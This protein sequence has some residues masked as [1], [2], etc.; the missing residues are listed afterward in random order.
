MV[1]YVDVR[2]TNLPEEC[3]DHVWTL[4]GIREQSHIFF[5]ASRK[6]MEEKKGKKI[7]NMCCLASVCHLIWLKRRAQPGQDACSVPG[8]QSVCSLTTSSTPQLIGQQQAAPLQ[9]GWLQTQA[10]MILWSHELTYKPLL[11]LAGCWAFSGWWN[12][13]LQCCLQHLRCLLGLEK[14]P[15]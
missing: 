7:V 1:I 2:L 10:E 8:C 6:S 3:L 11:Q 13:A 14:A 5:K 9:V 15:E 4:W 12:V